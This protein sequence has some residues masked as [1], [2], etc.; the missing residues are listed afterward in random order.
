AGEATAVILDINEYAQML[1]RLEETD[2]L[3]VLQEMRNK[4]LKLRPLEEFIQEHNPR[5]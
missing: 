1:E 2:D 3:A 5:V 4:P